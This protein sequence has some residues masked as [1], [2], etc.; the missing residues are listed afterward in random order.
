MKLSIGEAAKLSR[1]SVRT[2][3]YYDEIGLLKPVETNDSG[4]RFYDENALEK[5][6]I[7]LFYRELEFS[8][9]DISKIM[10]QPYYDKKESLL[11]QKELL[12]LKRERLDRLIALIDDTIKGDNDMSFEQFDNSEFE[13]LRDKYADE[14]EKLY[15][16]TDAYKESKKKAQK[17]SKEDWHTIYKESENIMSEFYSKKNCDVDS[18]EVFTLVEKWK[19]HITKYYYKCTK[20]ILQGLGLMYVNDERFK[21]NIDKHGEGTA[22]FMSAAINSYCKNNG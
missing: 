17:Y 21:N 22:E 7:I 18:E 12:K 13:N 11:K 2:L 20:E 9:K 6:Q 8:L 14:A 3:H 10:S 1:V 19:N 16:N 5:L 15:G 4:Y